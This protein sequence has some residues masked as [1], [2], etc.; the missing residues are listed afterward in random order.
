MAVLRLLEVVD[1]SAH[2]PALALKAWGLVHHGLG[3]RDG[4]VGVGR[5][6][7]PNTPSPPRRALPSISP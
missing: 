5:D 7:D 3:E 1:V 2:F 6:L 4:G